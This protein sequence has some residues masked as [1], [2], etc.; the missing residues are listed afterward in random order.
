MSSVVSA[1]LPSLPPPLLLAAAT[2]PHAKANG[3]NKLRTGV[4]GIAD[5]LPAKI[6]KMRREADSLLMDAHDVSAAR[7]AYKRTLAAIDRNDPY[8]NMGYYFDTNPYT[9]I[10][11]ASWTAPN[12]GWGFSYH[13][14]AWLGACSDA[15]LIY[16]ACLKYD[17]DSNPSVEPRVECLPLGV[18][19]SDGSPLSPYAYRERLAKVSTGGYADCIARPER[20]IRRPLK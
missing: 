11:K 18:I 6:K 1:L 14:V 20:K 13:E 9:A 3:N 10:G 15:D 5:G 8:Y 16:D 2:K 17:G 12:W 7:R 4:K 19:F